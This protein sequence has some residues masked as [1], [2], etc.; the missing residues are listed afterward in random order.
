M[1]L[2]DNLMLLNSAA[3]FNLDHGLH[4]ADPVSRRGFRVVP[5]SGFFSL[6]STLARDFFGRR[7]EL[8]HGVS[9]VVLPCPELKPFRC[10]ARL[11]YSTGELI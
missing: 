3:V 2:P 9:S 4:V 11:Q 10:R 8:W 7:Q 5:P 6:P 1:P